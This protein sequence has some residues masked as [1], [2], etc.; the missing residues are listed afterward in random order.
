[1]LFFSLCE[2]VYCL[3]KETWCTH[4]LV[5]ILGA[6]SLVEVRYR[7]STTNKSFLRSRVDIYLIDYPVDVHRLPV[8]SSRVSSESCSINVLYPGNRRV[9]NRLFCY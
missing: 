3:S 2:L 5:D 1:M 6:H 4:L 8:V 7:Y 9:V